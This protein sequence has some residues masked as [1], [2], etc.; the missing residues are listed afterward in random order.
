MRVS[1]GDCA[2]Y[3]HENLTYALA[4]NVKFM[5]DKIWTKDLFVRASKLELGRI[6]LTLG[7]NKLLFLI[8]TNCLN[9]M[10]ENL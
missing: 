4:V 6:K 1:F 2:V 9:D 3:A 8:S 5:V 10:S 7:G